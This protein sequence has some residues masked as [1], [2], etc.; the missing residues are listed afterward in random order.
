M[1]VDGVRA[2]CCFVSEEDS[3]AA[4]DLEA[5]CDLFIYL[6]EPPEA[7]LGVKFFSPHLKVIVNNPEWWI[8]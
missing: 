1:T 6:V 8:H 2:G 3:E 5:V 7:G 4:C